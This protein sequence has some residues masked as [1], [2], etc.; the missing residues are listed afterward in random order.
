MVGILGI[1]DMS[2]ERDLLKRIRLEM[3]LPADIEEEIDSI[4][5]KPEPEPVA[6]K[7]NT[8]IV[9]DAALTAALTAPGIAVDKSYWTPLYTSP[10][11]LPSKEL[12]D[13]EIEKI[14]SWVSPIDFGLTWKADAVTKYDLAIARAIEKAIYGDK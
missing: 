10:A 7:H 11:S 12:S 8:F 6:W 14:L 4:L 13:I 5:A 9:S 3:M 2:I 1:V